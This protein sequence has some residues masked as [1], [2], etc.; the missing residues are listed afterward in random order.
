ML[1]PF[2]DDDTVLISSGHRVG[3][4]GNPFPPDHLA[5]GARNQGPISLLRRESIE[6]SSETGRIEVVHSWKRLFGD[7]VERCLVTGR[8]LVSHEPV[9]AF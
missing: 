3:S 9:R 2:L 1:G 5:F 6:K 8:I 4:S 7:L